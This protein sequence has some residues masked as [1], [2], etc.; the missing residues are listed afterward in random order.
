MLKILTIDDKKDNLVVLNALLSDAFPDALIIEA[1]SGNEGL[2]KAASEKPDVII[3]DIVM[4]GMDGF[5]VC[6]KLKKD[7]LLKYI[8]IIILTA[9]KTDKASKIKMLNLGADAFLY[10]PV[11]ESELIA[12]ISAMIRLKKAE[13]TLRQENIRLEGLVKKRT[14]KLEEINKITLKLNEDLKIKDN[15]I[16][17]S[18]NGIAFADLQGNIFYVNDAF[19]KMFG[20]DSNEEIYSKTAMDLH[21]TE[22]HGDLKERWEFTIKNSPWQ[23]EIKAKKKNGELFDVQ[24]SA[25]LVK[26]D[27]G[28]PTSMMAA[29]DD[30]TVRKQAEKKLQN[31][32]EKLQATNEDLM[33][34]NI[35]LKLSLNSSNAGNWD[36]DIANNKFY[37]SDEFLKIFGMDKTVKPGF[38]AWKNVLYPEDIEEASKRIK[39]AIDENKELI[40]DYRIVLP[41][42]KIRWIR[43]T[44]KT[45]YDNNNPIRMIGLCMDIT[46]RKQAEQKIIEY[47][48]Y[49]DNLIKSIPDTLIVIDEN[50]RIK[51]VNQALLD[52]LKYNEKDVINQ[53]IGKVFAAAVKNIILGKT[54]RDIRV[55]YQTGTGEIIPISLSGSAMH[56]DAGNVSA[57]ILIGRDMRQQIKMQEDIVASEKKHREL[58]ENMREGLWH[59]N[60]NAVTV[61]VNPEME[62]ILGYSAD[63][64]IGKPLW[65]FMD[66]VWK[67]KAEKK[68]QQEKQ[69]GCGLQFE[70]GFKH[71]NGQIII[72]LMN[73]FP[74][75][76]SGKYNG[77]M[78]TLIDITERKQNEQKIQDLLEFNQIIINTSFI[79]IAVYKAIGQCVQINQAVAA[80]IGEKEEELLSQNFRH[81]EVWKKSGMLQSAEE[82]LISGKKVSR[83]IQT[84]TTFGKEVWYD[85]QFIL[86]NTKNESHLLVMLLDIKERKQA[87]KKIIKQNIELKIKDNAIETAINGIS[88][89]DMQGNVFYANNSFVKMTEYNREELYGKTPVLFHPTDELENL[90]KALEQIRTKGFWQGELK[91][92]KK[93][94]VLFDAY[95]S[96]SL[97]KDDSGNPVCMMAVFEDITERKQAEIAL[98]ESEEIQSTIIENLP[99]G[100]III[101]AATRIIEKVNG[102]AQTLFGASKEM[103]LGKRCHSFI[104]PAQEK[105]CPI[106]DLGQIVDNSERILLTADGSSIPIL[107]SVTKINKKGV[108]KLLECFVDITE[109]KQAEEK[110]KKAKEAAESANRIK[111]QFLA[112]MSHEIRTPMNAIMGM[113]YL[114]LEENL[115]PK[116]RE[117]IE[118]VNKSANSLL[119]IINDILDMSKIEA[120]KVE[121]EHAD[122]DLNDI[123][124]SL[125]DMFSIISMGKN[126]KFQTYIQKEVSVSLNGDSNRLKQIL[127]NLINNA[128]KFTREGEVRLTV[129]LIE[130]RDD[131]IKLQFSVRDTGIGISEENKIKLFQPFSQVDGSATRKFG[132]TGLGLVISKHLVELMGGEIWVESEINKGSEFSFTAVLKQGRE[133][134]KDKKQLSAITFS[135]L[136][137]KKILL[138]EDNE[139]NHKLIKEVLKK[140]EVNIDIAS[141]GKEA[142]DLLAA[143][144]YDLV[145]MDIQMPVMDGYTAT[146]EIRKN[147]VYKNLPII[148]MTANAMQSDIQKCLEI[149]MNDHIAKPIETKN[150]YEKLY[151]WLEVDIEECEVRGLKG[152]DGFKNIQEKYSNLADDFDISIV[153]E[154]TSLN[155]NKFNIMLTDYYEKYK[156]YDCRILESINGNDFKQARFLTH[157]VSGISG[158]LGA[159]KVSETARELEGALIKQDILSINETFL[160][161]SD[162]LRKTMAVI[163]KTLAAIETFPDNPA[164]NNSE[165]VKDYSDKG[166]IY[167]LDDDRTIL[168]VIERIINFNGIGKIECFDNSA[169]FYKALENKLPDIIL[170]D[171]NMPD[172]NGIDVCLRLKSEE[173]MKD[174]PIVFISANNDTE[175]IVKGFKA[176]A[177]DYIS[178][179]Y[180]ANEMIS[181][182]STHLELKKRIEELKI[183]TQ[184]LIQSE[185]MGAVGQL[186]VGIAHEFN[187]VL[188]MIYNN[189]QLIEIYEKD[190]LSPTSLEDV[191]VIKYAAKR[192]AAIAL[193]LMDFAKPKAP[194]KEL[195]KIEDSI[196]D[197]LKLQRQQLILENIEINKDYRYIGKV[198]IDAAQFQQ[199][200][201]NMIINARHAI[202]PK[203]KG[204][205]SVSVK[206]ANK[207]IEIR[208]ADDGIGIDKEHLNNIFTPFFST[209]GAYAKDSH[210]IEGT[211]LGL[212]VTYSIIQQHNGT[213]RVESEKDKGATF[214]IELPIPENKIEIIEKKP[215][216]AVE[217]D[218]ENISLN[219]LIVD[220][221]HQII[222]SMTRMFK[223][224]NCTVL[225]SISGIDGVKLAKE[226]KFD[227]IFMD[228]LL[229][230]I[231]GEKMFS[232]IQKFDKET[233]I[234]FISGQIGLETEKL[235][236]LGAYGFLQK[237]FGMDDLEKI[238]NEIRKQKI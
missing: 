146:K 218:I 77:S 83:E 1:L 190:K 230:D 176:G 166:L 3:L 228:M 179:P 55:E 22:G 195:S 217:C 33:K 63:E 149:G 21:P 141:N 108:E 46:E 9:A 38:A 154:R 199:V 100:V 151:K 116:I 181:R 24:L 214:I 115:H 188:A 169:S 137:S 107:K 158:S 76:E 185:K 184:Q 183:I 231:S 29:F 30:I 95:L 92:K 96:T 130:K 49:V 86:F 66:D 105:E 135:S 127:I 122:F 215:D 144:K 193:N 94:G 201:L 14:E 198:F 90:E 168:D 234:I 39:D 2:E 53:D 220:D 78:A 20:Y 200:F 75:I 89:A 64:M 159:K 133:I 97:V 123:V 124:K 128:V 60:S 19:V 37:W 223:I 72:V 142:L 12:Q 162:A 28:C 132:G 237:P 104:C 165:P 23:G 131:K 34:A 79:G 233:P 164:S 177:I 148:A 88:F 99:A 42:K 36:W 80:I 238:L 67:K 119:T 82:A 152:E 126:L 7:A 203:S 110:L 174:I 25:S 69:T 139:I 227:I 44:G 109:R 18:I 191:E 143:N 93:N 157:S 194:K 35:E 91:T 225:S 26:D 70:F 17:T 205:I 41:D 114:C 113:S 136:K 118:I 57:V 15:A 206:A 43:A 121:I 81:N 167:I 221:E 207:N 10:K 6:E 138:V 134:V 5:E 208:I 155:E 51:T 189:I 84:V 163:E 153:K 216:E 112:N 145:L 65:D 211:G 47:N 187:N 27:S 59:I 71:K 13:D 170:L 117:Y 202:L 4:P 50:G 173:K 32:A 160:I 224:N 52:L 212:A 232:E 147:S 58:I 196:E 61:F 186:A 175:T 156:E 180:I 182:I 54:V 235:K 209:K 45:I 62:R 226:N 229:P 197:A 103:I 161:F 213:V 48:R 40:N 150:L 85:A 102:V 68:F 120:G 56:D 125:S 11:D 111:S 178:K 172:V 8:P 16:E 129:S 236:E 222:S 31:M 74:F 98:A 101:D 204:K 106:C 87:E 140:T 192:G 219:I 210:G 171:I 73:T